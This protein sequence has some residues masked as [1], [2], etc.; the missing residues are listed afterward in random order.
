MSASGW[1]P[2]IQSYLVVME[3]RSAVVKS[4]NGA[5]EHQH[6]LFRDVAYHGLTGSQ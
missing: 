2:G 5:L 4:D 3:P 6:K 1:Y